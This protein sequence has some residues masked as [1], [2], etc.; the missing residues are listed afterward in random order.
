MKYLTQ[1]LIILISFNLYAQDPYLQQTNAKFESEAQNITKAYNKVLALTSKQ[2]VLFEKKVE[3][4]LIRR[5]K[6]ENNYKAKE[7]LNL[8]YEMQKVE[9]REMNDI[10]TK[11]Q[12]NLYKRI[13]PKI[14]PLDE[15][16]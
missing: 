9:T 8:L 13:K 4:F 14:Q 3:E 12:L 16:N 2:F 11:P 5:K 10:L 1:I 15:V 7:K 6:I